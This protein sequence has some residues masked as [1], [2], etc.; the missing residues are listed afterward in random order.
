MVLAGSSVSGNS[1]TASIVKFGS[2]GKQQW[3]DT[4]SGKES[5]QFEDVAV[6]SDGSVIAVGT[7]FDDDISNFK[8]EYFAD[9]GEKGMGDCLMVKYSPKGKFEWAKVLGGTKSDLFYS[10]AACPGG[11]FVA[12]SSVKS[13]NGDFASVSNISRAEQTSAVLIKF[14][15]NNASSIAWAKSMSSSKYVCVEGLDVAKNG[16]VFASIDVKYP[17]YDFASI[18]NSDIGGEKTLIVKY[19]QGGDYQWQQ[20]VCSSAR[21]YMP[22]IIADNEGGCVAAGYFSAAAPTNENNLGCL[23]TFSQVYNAGNAGTAD[24]AVVAFGSGGS[25]KW[26]TVLQGFYADF[27]TDIIPTATGYVVAGYSNSTNRDFSSMPGAGDY[28]AFVCALSPFGTRQTMLTLGGS[29]ADKIQGVCALSD[30]TI[31]FCGSTASGDRSFNAM[32]P[33]GSSTSA[34]SFASKATLVY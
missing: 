27:R 4:I 3:S 2:N 26:L 31:G 16:D 22:S 15:D 30:G 21:A 19:S 10:V 8:G 6:L 33:S 18:P 28:D 23:G 20:T 7:T 24:G 13:V 9:S 12:G 32:S 5:I 34:A 11:G 1:S 17:D 29:D 14:A 25:V